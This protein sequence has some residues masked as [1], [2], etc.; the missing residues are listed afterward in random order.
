MKDFL[1]KKIIFQNEKTCR[2]DKFLANEFSNF[3]RM[4]W[5]RAINKGEVFV[6]EKKI[7]PNYDLKKGDEIEILIKDQAGDVPIKKQSD[8]LLDIFFENENFLIINK[9][10][11]I[12]VHDSEKEKDI[13]LVDIVG[14]KFAEIKNIGDNP[15][16]PGIVHRLDKETSGLLIV[17][18]SKKA[19][20]FFQKAFKEK[21]IEKEYM[22]LVW[23]VVKKDG[24]VIEGFVG[25]SKSNPTKQAFSQ[26][27]DKVANPKESLTKYEV[28]K[29][30]KD[31]TLVKLFPK[32]GRTHQ[33]RLHLHGIGYPIVGD[34]K[35]ANK[36]VRMEN[37]KYPRHLL[38]ASRLKFE[39]EGEKYDFKSPAKEIIPP[40]NLNQ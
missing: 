9:P 23:G 6:C 39:F 21:V 37:K 29:R 1:D 22:A 26:Q 20:D 4:F 8:F 16:R 28:I 17:A 14:R 32:T 27:S 34:K 30:F 10:A 18:R 38:H 33:I 13:S 40:D 36:K 19:F 25:K 2:L 15:K 5:K 24:G 35:Y 7:K 12:S 31:K 11:G 3:P